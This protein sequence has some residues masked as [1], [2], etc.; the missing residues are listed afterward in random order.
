M[1]CL[2]GA[3]SPLAITSEKKQNNW[4]MR[5]HQQQHNVPPTPPIPISPF[6]CFSFSLVFSFFLSFFFFLLVPS[7]SIF[8]FIYQNNTF[9]ESSAQVVRKGIPPI[10]MPFINSA[11]LS[12]RNQKNKI[13]MKHRYYSEMNQTTFSTIAV[14]TCQW[15]ATSHKIS[16]QHKKIKNTK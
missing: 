11:F 9:Q 7:I 2:L 8:L 13:K 3:S 15:T 5:R 1:C 16:T 12:S 6:P 10:D 14:M 4:F